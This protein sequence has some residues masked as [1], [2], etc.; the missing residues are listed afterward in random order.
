MERIL[1]IEDEDTVRAMLRRVLENAGYE[2]IEA[3]NGADALYLYESADADVVITD[4]IMPEMDGFDAIRGLRERDPD[5]RIVAVT[6][7]EDSYLQVAV[8]YGAEAVLMKP[9]DNA[10]LL[11]ALE[12]GLGQRATI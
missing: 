4:I 10:S 1:L 12:S 3:R 8:H 9:F 7:G 6:G 11:S 5:L 2:V